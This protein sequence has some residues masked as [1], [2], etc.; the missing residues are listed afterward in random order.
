MKKVEKSVCWICKSEY[1][2]DFAANEDE[3]R[4]I[5]VPYFKIGDTINYQACLGS[6]RYG[7]HRKNRTG[8]VLDIWFPVPSKYY[9]GEYALLHTY[10]VSYLVRMA[11]YESGS[12]ER[13]FDQE[14]IELLQT[15]KM[16][17]VV[18]EV[19]AFFDDGTHIDARLDANTCRLR[20]TSVT[21]W[22]DYVTEVVRRNPQLKDRLTGFTAKLRELNCLD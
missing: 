4:G 12:G 1:D 2:S 6:D 19:S 8:T 10:Q 17:E 13:F 3:A 21:N 22:D 7:S 14:N 9:R 18:S 16:V 5:L 11:K 15:I 20:M